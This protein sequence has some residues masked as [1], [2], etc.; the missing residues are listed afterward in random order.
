VVS[1]AHC[2]F[3]M[4]Y[5]DGDWLPSGQTAGATAARLD[6]AAVARLL[7]ATGQ[8]AAG[9]SAL[10]TAGKLHRDIKPSNVLVARDGRVVLLDFGLATA[11][12][13]DPGADAS[14]G[15]SGSFA[16][17]PPEHARAPLDPSADWSASVSCSTRR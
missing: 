1:D 12:K 8:L 16:Y 11:L 10:H 9:L 6:E 3:T 2:F 14:A 5:V 17:A 15:F 13:L 4:E 7:D